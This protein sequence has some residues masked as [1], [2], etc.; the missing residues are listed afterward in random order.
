CNPT[1]QCVFSF[2]C[3]QSLQITNT[4]SVTSLSQ[5]EKI[6]NNFFCLPHVNQ[7]GKL[8]L[9]SEFPFQEA[10]AVLAGVPNHLNFLYDVI[11]R[12]PMNLLL[13]KKYN[14]EIF[15]VLRAACGREALSL[16]AEQIAKWDSES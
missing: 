1:L 14:R 6:G 15:L 5:V 2:G 4:G 7:S 9:G 3:G 11:N 13:D 10:K 16:T 12:I 8:V